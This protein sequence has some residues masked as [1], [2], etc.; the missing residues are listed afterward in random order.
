MRDQVAWWPHPCGL[1]VS[2]RDLMCV[3]IPPFLARGCVTRGGH[4]PQIPAEVWELRLGTG[5][6]WPHRP[7]S[8]WAWEAGPPA[9]NCPQKSPRS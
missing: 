5:S 9:L 8:L 6:Q 4:C 3:L 7:R 2:C 1:S